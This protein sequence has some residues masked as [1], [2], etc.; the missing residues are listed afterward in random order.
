MAFIKWFS[1]LLTLLFLHTQAMSQDGRLYWKYKDYDGAKALRIGGWTPKFASLFIKGKEERRLTRR[2]G[3]VRFLHFEDQDNPVRDS[4]INRLVRRTSNEGGLQELI[5]VRDGNTRVHVLGKERGGIIR[6]MV[7]LVQEPESFT[8]VSLKGRL[9][10]KD[11][12]AVIDKHSKKTIKKGTRPKIP[13]VIK[14]PV[15]TV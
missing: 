2:M 7:V 5:M 6:K 14:V 10:F 9:R 1:C 3:K 12:Q 11:I 13:A 4:D 15:E 8:F